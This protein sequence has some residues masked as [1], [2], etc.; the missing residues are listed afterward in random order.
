MIICGDVN[1]IHPFWSP[2]DKTRG[3][4]A[5]QTLLKTLQRREPRADEG[6]VWQETTDE[7]RTTASQG[8][9]RAARAE[10]RHTPLPGK[11]WNSIP[12]L[13][14]S[15]SKIDFILLL[16]WKGKLA[17]ILTT[18]ASPAACAS[19]NLPIVM[20]ITLHPQ[21]G[22]F[23]KEVLL[24]TPHHMKA[25]AVKAAN[26]LYKEQLPRLVSKMRACGSKIAFY[27]HVKELQALFRKPWMKN[28]KLKPQCHT[29]EW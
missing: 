15:G 13:S 17:S 14:I 8:F 7:Q 4:N 24:F 2:S 9:I 20:S 19:E 27:A 11:G 23:V 28:V 3:G 5:L 10:K 29:A 12:C 21:Q 26:K 22:E 25:N 16:G 1:A 6:E 18:L